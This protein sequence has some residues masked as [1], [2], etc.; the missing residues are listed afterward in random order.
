MGKNTLFENFLYGA[1]F[2]IE[3]YKFCKNEEERK[4]INN[5]FDHWVKGGVRKSS[6]YLLEIIQ[7][8]RIISKEEKKLWGDL[9]GKLSS[10]VHTIKN[11]PTGKSIKCK[12]PE[13]NA[14]YSDVQFDKDNLIEWAKY[15]Q[16][17]FSLI[18]YKL[19]CL[20]PCI[21][22]EEAGKLA[23]R[24]FRDTFKDKRKELDNPYLDEILK[25]RAVNS[26]SVKNNK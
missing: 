23:L 15:Y 21:K 3:Y 6:E 16:K 7:K 24:Q 26:A 4:D 22:R 25:M 13:F 2:S 17:V 11:T 19:L 5:K 14:C 12:D 18:L 10:F 9:F 1:Y 20:Y 8:G